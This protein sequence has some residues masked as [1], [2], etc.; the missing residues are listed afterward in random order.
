MSLKEYGIFVAYP[1][2]VDLRDQGLGRY[3]ALFLKGAGELSDIRFTIVCPSWSRKTLLDLFA[4]EQVPSNIYKIVSPHGRPYA[5]VF[6]EF[7]RSYL[8]KSRSLGFISR[9]FDF[10]S[11]KIA[12]SW[13]HVAAKAVAVH[14]FWSLL[15]FLFVFIPLLVVLLP[16]G[17]IAVPFVILAAILRLV[18]ILRSP[19]E[20]KL[21]GVAWY[22]RLK[23]VNALLKNPESRRWVLRLFDEMHRREISRMHDAIN[24]L[25]SVRAWYCPAV[26]WPEFNDIRAPRLM[27]V[28]DV[29]LRDFPVGFAE[30]DR[31]DYFSSFQ[32]IG[33]AIRGGDSFVTYSETVKWNTLVDGYGVKAEKISVIRH[34]P[35]KLNRLLEI[36]GFPDLQAT[37]K[38]YCQNLFRSAMQRSLNPEYTAAFQNADVKYLFYASQ[39]RPN[40]NVLTLLRAYEYLLRK[41]HFGFKL[42]MT[43]IPQSI[44]QV[45]DFISYHRLEND[46]IFLHALTLPQLAACYRLATLAV[47]PT[48]SEGGCPFTFT[49]ALSVGTP[50]VMSRITVAEEVL[51]DPELQEKTFFD[52]YDWKDC[53]RRI[54]WAI[55]HRE[56]LLQVQISAYTLL[57]QRTWSDVVREHVSVMDS[58]IINNCVD[59][60]YA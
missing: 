15:K 38:K 31:G 18:M 50:V 21:R 19:I 1:P 42:V 36:T 54:E 7:I 25:D 10:L 8:T 2:S 48:L 16:I 30:L 52:P 43:G 39:F 56:E 27:C 29:V 55:E 41:R 53:A 22:T 45:R 13:Y 40:K 11:N 6:F 34:A 32:S 49:E 46:V 51:T 17:I 9:A 33:N 37:S 28:P 14:S 20:S 3:L 5:L 24:V 4:S 44:P 35:N 47:N 60:E 59:H 26:F 23:Q 57:E 12:D 58:M